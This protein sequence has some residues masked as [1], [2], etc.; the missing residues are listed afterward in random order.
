[1]VK[2]RET[3]RRARVRLE[4]ERRRRF[5]AAAESPRLHG[6]DLVAHFHVLLVVH[7]VLDQ[8]FQYVVAR[9]YRV[10]F[11][12]D[13]LH[14]REK[15][16]GPR[17]RR[18]VYVFACCSDTRVFYAAHILYAHIYSCE[19]TSQDGKRWEAGDGKCFECV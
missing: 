11:R 15:T 13:V 17:I 4:R 10:H 5:F 18:A 8:V 7:D 19:R 2:Q 3:E 16:D 12:V 6:I 14:L 1:M 9:E